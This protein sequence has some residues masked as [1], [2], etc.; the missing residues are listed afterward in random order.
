MTDTANSKSTATLFGHPRGVFLLA[1]AEMWER[2]SFF[3]M[4]GLLVLFLTAETLD[5]GFGWD[6]TRAIRFYGL[7]GFTLWTLP[8]LGGWLAD[9]LLGLRLA[10]FLG[11]TLM[12]FGHF[13]MA[14]PSFFPALFEAFF[15]FPI[16]DVLRQS[17]VQLGQLILSDMEISRIATLL[18]NNDVFGDHQITV[19][20]QAAIMSY[21]FSSWSF[22]IALMLIMFGNA[23]FKPSI[24]VLPGELYSKNDSRRDG[25]YTILYIAINVGSL[26]ANFVAGTLGEKLGWDYGFS[27][28]GIGMV[29]GLSLLLWKYKTWVGPYGLAP[30][31]KMQPLSMQS[32]KFSHEE[33][34]HIKAISLLI[35][36]MIF[37]IC[38]FEQI[39]GLVN[40]FIHRYTDRV[41]LG[42]E[43]PATWF[44]SLNPI[45]ILLFAPFFAIL[46]QKLDSK[47]GNP[48]PLTKY[49]FGMLLIGVAFIMLFC[50]AAERTGSL[51][52][53]SNLL[54][55]VATYFFLTV[56]ELLIFPIFMAQIP[57]LA[58]ER[59]RGLATGFFFFA[60]GIGS[61]L[62]G[63]IGALAQEFGETKIFIGI[64]ISTCVAGML[65]YCLAQ[66][67]RRWTT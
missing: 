55:I 21:Y 64:A 13:L 33:K 44:L 4:R 14:G 6:S 41:L 8:I 10:I 3:G 46:W 34:K 29:I 40:F 1:G 51:D 18:A 5:A 57:K 7:Y 67:Y 24:V 49:F 52:D 43:I 19:Y 15:G 53:K 2:F 65:S 60:M 59:Y 11:G 39:G 37:F 12:V 48:D 17:G 66:Q 36:F 26:L 35:V 50:A 61:Y 31:H 62:S 27:A 30:T 63:Q 54:W 38:A 56:G 9:R 58:P 32:L 20:H 42:F 28:A 22:Y 23:L 45:F 25:A 16:V 47:G